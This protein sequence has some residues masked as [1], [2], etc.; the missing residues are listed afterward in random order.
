MSDEFDREAERE[1][2]REKYGDDEEERA[3]T[4]RMSELL[5]KGATMTNRHC[6]ECGDPVF[7][8]E[9]QEF[10]PTCRRE[11]A[12]G[13]DADGE[14]GGEDDPTPE[15]DEQRATPSADRTGTN[16]RSAGVDG[17]DRPERSPE[18]ADDRP[19]RES[20]GEAIARATD[21]A[22]DPRSAARASL[23]RTLARTARRAEA[24]DDPRT[25][26]DWLTAAREAAAA[27]AALDGRQT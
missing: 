13:V 16:G 5:L 22:D 10:C 3:A 14:S 25:T 8:H 17:R 4:Q 9:G 24:A 23:E 12:E 15:T 1:R 11:V 19:I 18:T 20:D 21:D 6:G 7:R 26:R 27:L 2:L